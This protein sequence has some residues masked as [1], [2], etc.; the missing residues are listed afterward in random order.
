MSHLSLNNDKIIYDLI[1][2]LSYKKE[3]ENDNKFYN[4]VFYKDLNANKWIIHDQYNK[5]EIKDKSFEMPYM[6]FYIK[7]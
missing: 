6:L 5:K 7:K 4:I 3:P 2:I 1:G